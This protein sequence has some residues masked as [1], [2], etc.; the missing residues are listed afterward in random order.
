MPTLARKRQEYADAVRLAFA[1]GEEGLDSV[2]WHQICIDVPRTNSGIRLWQGAET[3]R[4]SFGLSF[5]A[6]LFCFISYGRKETMV[7]YESE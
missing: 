4:V 6:S 7:A 2:I 1:K 5:F 3:Q